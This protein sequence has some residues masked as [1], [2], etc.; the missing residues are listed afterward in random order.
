MDAGF[1]PAM[2]AANRKVQ[3]LDYNQHPGACVRRFFI[4]GGGG[5]IGSNLTNH[6]LENRLGAVTIY[7][8]FSVGRRVHLA[9]QSTNPNLQIISADVADKPLLI[10][11][12]AH[13]DLVFHFAAN[14][15]IARAANEPNVD[16][17]NGT[18]LTEAVLEAMR[19]TKTKRILFTS[20]S[21]VY[22][23]APP[24]AL[25]EDYTP[26]VPVSTYGASKLASEALIAAYCHMFD[27]T[28]I[29][30]RFANVVGPNMTHG[31]SH[32]FINRLAQR[33]HR[34]LIYGDGMQTKPYIH[35]SDVI[36]AMLLAQEHAQSGYS[37]YNVASQDQL[38]VN[39]IARIVIDAM[40]LRDVE[41]E[42]TGGSRGWR[43]DVPVYRLDSSKIRQLGWANQHNSSEAV[44]AAVTARLY[45]VGY[46]K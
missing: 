3:S 34:L 7:D 32:D 4:T 9:D 26:M 12:M 16:F 37:Y 33:P 46:E 15:D 30:L 29:V 43:A 8:N 38:T 45:E 18:V 23:D 36:N 11:A 27:I 2:F 14:S 42:Y 22:G 21:G 5:F 44:H 24:V 28:G 10:E 1:G 41:F 40:N 13:H 39:Q 25:A 6:I 35:V 17:A 31:V 20:G 19:V